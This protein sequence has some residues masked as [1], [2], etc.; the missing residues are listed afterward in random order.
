M[1]NKNSAKP[2]SIIRQEINSVQAA[3]QQME[4][5]KENQQ[6]KLESLNS[7]FL[8]REITVIEKKAAIEQ[9][10]ERVTTQ[11]YE[12]AKYDLLYFTEYNAQ[13]KYYKTVVESPISEEA[14]QII[15]II[16]K[17]EYTGI[18][19]YPNA[20]QWNPV[21]RPQQMMLDLA[22][23]GY[24][25]FFC[26]TSQSV[27]IHKEQEGMYVISN[28]SHLLQALQTYHVLVLNS[29]LMQ[30]AWIEHL[31][32][33]TIWYDVLD[34]VDFFSFYD[35]GMLAAHYQNLYEADIVTYS[36]QA[37]SEYVS[38]R[39]DA[40]Y[41]P[42]AVNF[43]DFVIINQKN[44]MPEDLSP[45]I[46][47]TSKIIGYYGAIEEWFDVELISKLANQ[48][49]IKIILIGYCGLTEIE[50]PENVHLL[51]PKPYS[52]LKQYT[53]FFDAMIIPFLVNDLTNAV[54]PVKFFE[55]CAI[56]KPIITTP[57]A[58]VLQYEGPGITLVNT[59][60]FVSLEPS[61]WRMESNAFHHLRK[62]ARE[63]Q[64]NQRTSTVLDVLE[65]IPAFLPVL[66]NRVY[67]KTQVNVFAA[68][69]LDYK[70]ENYYSGGAERYLVDL[71]EVCEDLGLK[72]NIYQYGHFSWYRKYK[73]ID[74]YS[75]GHKMLDMDEF[76]MENLLS[77]SRRF[78]YMAKGHSMLNIYSA[79]FQS[80]PNV[81]HPSIGISHGVAW[82]SPHS[83]FENGTQFWNV[84]ERYIQSAD[85]LQK[86]VSVDTNTANWF[87]TVSY[88]T[89]L[90]IETIP[91]YVDRTEF[92]PVQRKEDGK[93]R[94]VY[95]RR[96]YR[97]RG[98]YI[99]LDIVD[100]ILNDYPNA[101]F[102]FVGKGFPEDLQ[103][104]Y[105]KMEQW[106]GRIYCYHSE[107]EDMH[108]VYKKADIV[109]IPTL[110]SEGTSLSCLEACATG[111][112][113][114]A[115]RVGGLTDI[116]IDHHNGL[117][118]HPDQASLEKA[119]RTCLDNPELMKKIGENAIEVS[120]A[121]NKD[122]WKK[123]WKDV[124]KELLQ[125]QGVE[126]DYNSAG[127]SKNEIIEIVIGP[128][129]RQSKWLPYVI[130]CLKQ[131]MKVFIRSGQ[132]PEL[133]LNF[134]R[135]QWLPLDAEVYFEPDVV[136]KF[137]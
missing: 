43:E 84:N 46:D 10:N 98:L 119:V 44:D 74:V 26:D 91:N 62:I 66:A 17:Y 123:R 132:K 30:N 118:I 28:Q 73:D 135:I 131:G 1:I 109:L 29:W 61:F 40:V 41:L 128:N 31:P 50:F 51:G 22:K 47:G 53:T 136:K 96:L 93:I 16:Q 13:Y 42:N 15:K 103:A 70:G 94:I 60:E 8:N 87:Q 68:T 7:E 54:S 92:F 5:I 6:M 55:Y 95:P 65:K 11:N 3:L 58:E 110:Y 130:Q 105:D 127:N 18:V 56:G 24:L 137:V 36:A 32:H 113:V 100:N 97:P 111:N 116:I 99:T 121:F 59:D 14:I 52:E 83:Q 102:H 75:L 12:L 129:V 9:L 79:F 101:E 67:D 71:H 37:L 89:S 35:K 133:D 104:I 21:Q 122:I 63:N 85:D 39:K 76:T 57:I 77:F 78:D 134:A 117:L 106:T 38:K 90:K 126:W 23:R 64:W 107:P 69:F 108:A 45:L 2:Y 124:V 114:I 125:E 20:V 4:L 34:R 19:V 49:N 112:A 86:V 81:A 120:K 48:K 88:G 115:T 33:K 82:D 27:D 72:L 25:C 80:Y